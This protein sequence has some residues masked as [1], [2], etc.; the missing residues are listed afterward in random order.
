[1]EIK[2]DREVLEYVSKILNS[3]IEDLEEFDSK[4]NETEE[5]IN[6]NSL[7]G[8]NSIIE[9]GSIDLLESLNRGLIENLEELVNGVEAIADTFEALDTKLS[10]ETSK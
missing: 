7:E 2:T 1:M 5:T 3:Q 4:L 10:K 8:V 9:N 6:S